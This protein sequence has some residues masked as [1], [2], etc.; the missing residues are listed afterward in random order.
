MSRIHGRFGEASAIYRKSDLFVAGQ[1][2]REGT[3]NFEIKNGG[4]S[5]KGVALMLSVRKVKWL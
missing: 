5:L 2:R 4:S 3:G 1:K